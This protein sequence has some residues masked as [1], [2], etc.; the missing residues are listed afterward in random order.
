MLER[1]SL[2][3]Y[4]SPCFDNESRIII[5]MTPGSFALFKVELAEIEES[6]ALDA[7]LGTHFTERDVAFIIL[8]RNAHVIGEMIAEQK[9]MLNALDEG[10]KLLVK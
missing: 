5:Y 10:I 7:A 3:Y 1:H 2:L 9:K 8:Q 6:V 4:V